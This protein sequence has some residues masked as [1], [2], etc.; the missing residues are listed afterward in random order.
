MR[1]WRNT[2]V[3]TLAPGQTATLADGTLGYEWDEDLDNGSRPAGL[4]RLSSTTRRRAVEQLQDYGSTYGAGHGHPPPDPVPRTRS[5]ALV[6]GAGTVQWSWGLDGNHDRGGAPRRRAHAAGD[7][8]PVRR[9]GRRSR[10]RCS[11]A[12]SPR[13]ASTDTAAPT[14]TITSPAAGATVERGTAGHD[15]GHRDRRR[16][17]RRRRRRGLGRRRADLAPGDRPRRAGATPG[18]REQDGPVTIRSA[19][20]RRQRQPR[21]RRRRARPSSSARRARGLPVLDLRGH[22][23]PGARRRLD[24]G[25]AVEL[26]REVPRRRRR[27]HHR[28]ALLQGHAEHRHARRAPV[29]RT[30]ARCSPRRRSP[31]RRPRGWQQVTLDTPVAVTADTTYVA[32]YHTP[33]GHYAV[34][35]ALLRHRRAQPA[36]ARR[37]PTASTAPTACYST[38]PAAF[39]TDTFNAA[40]Y[41]V[42]VVFEQLVAPDTRRAADR[43][44]VAGRRRAR[45]RPGRTSVTARFDE[46]MDAATIN[47]TTFELRDRR[48][49]SVAADVA[50]DAGHA[51]G[52]ADAAGGAGA[53]HD[54]HG[55]G[56]GRARRA[57]VKD[58]A[59]NALAADHTWSFTTADAAAPAARRRAG[60]ADPR[61]QRRRRPVRPLLRRDPARR[62]PQRVH[63]HGPRRRS[64][65]P[66]S[67]ATTS[68]I[69]AQTALSDAQA[70]MLDTWVNGGGNL[71]AMRPDASSRACSASRAAGGTLA[72]AY[73]QVEHG[74]STG[75]RHHRRDDAVP[76]HGRP[77]HAQRR[78]GGRHAVLRRRPRPRPTRP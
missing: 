43:R 55:D 8:Q 65:R 32:S 5:G 58:R 25:Q 1:F 47:G 3:A 75:R 28:R 49:T 11:R 74:R 14:S 52:H 35:R 51:H 44:R 21:E 53:L 15:R 10:R 76:R 62:G 68:S 7:G 45:R 29:D 48:R 63:G 64:P 41:W 70:S 39:P 61:H 27:L 20:R 56:P 46:P 59:G 34:R 37:W 22:E 57:G 4:I 16:R 26:G 67:R 66:R 33:A 69:L 9:H 30:A 24:D 36:A 42:D 72:D 12:W 17:R 78:D 77:L 54:L 13:R 71:I 31:A 2:S 6:F 38:A 73:L 18:R 60:R 23:T 40:N 50:Y 19:R